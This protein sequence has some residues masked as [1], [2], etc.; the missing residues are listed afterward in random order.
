[1]DTGK[2]ATWLSVLS[3]VGGIL[4]SSYQ[5]VVLN[6]QDSKQEALTASL[7]GAM[8][9]E[10]KYLREEIHQL[11]LELY[12]SK[13]QL[14]DLEEIVAK[15]EVQR[16]SQKQMRVEGSGGDAVK[17]ETLLRA[18]DEAVPTPTPS[19][20]EMREQAVQGKVWREGQWCDF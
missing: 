1:M 6:R 15:L 8:Q 14:N 18:D 3:V 7:M 10:Q 20:N 2:K 12:A 13:E 17:V 4:A 11:R 19:F 9:E 5:L 16:L